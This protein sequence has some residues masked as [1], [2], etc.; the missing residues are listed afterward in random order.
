MTTRTIQ[1]TA[2]FTR[3]F[4]MP[5][6]GAVQPAGSYLVETDEELLM[7]VSFPVY[8]RVRTLMHLH[9]VSGDPRITGIAN[10]DP[11]ELEAALLRDALPE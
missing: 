1:K 2:I 7:D 6:L 5:R 4:L 9:E 10:I 3:P 11:D 8:R